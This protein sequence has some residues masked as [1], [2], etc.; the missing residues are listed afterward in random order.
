M[1]YLSN[2]SSKAME[3]PDFLI[4]NKLEQIVENFKVSIWIL[5]HKC[6]RENYSFKL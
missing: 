2:S 6:Y 1:K 3:N 4:K 5:L